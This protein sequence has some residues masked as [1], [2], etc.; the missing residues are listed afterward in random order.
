MLDVPRE[1][2]PPPSLED[3]VVAALSAEG[4]VRGTSTTSRRMWMQAAAAAVFFLVGALAGANWSSR[5]TPTAP[6]QPRFL[7]LLEGG[8]TPPGEEERRAVEAYR[9]WAGGLRDG[10]RFITGE[11]LAA[12][13]AVVPDA[14]LD[15]AEDV[16][17]YFVVSAN[18]LADAAAVAKAS[19]HV[20]RGGRIIVRPIETP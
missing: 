19:P 20:A 10:G 2:P 17:G 7:L 14:A 15:D 3:R 9:A 6:D 4:L 16:Q 5:V 18:D 8:E 11:R 12:A 1:L 13:A